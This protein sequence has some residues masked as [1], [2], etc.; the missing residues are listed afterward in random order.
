[1]TFGND[2]FDGDAL[3][4]D[5]EER[6]WTEN[7]RR[8]ILN[9]LSTFFYSELNLARGWKLCSFWVGFVVVWE[10]CPQSYIMCFL[11]SIFFPLHTRVRRPDMCTP[12]NM[13]KSF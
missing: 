4:V 5:Y 7:I 8:R 11:T 6:I 13:N 2:G 9:K 1:M 12:K 3:L 10:E